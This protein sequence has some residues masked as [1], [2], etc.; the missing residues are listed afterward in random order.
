MREVPC[1]NPGNVT[2]YFDLRLRVELQF[3]STDC[4]NSRFKYV[5]VIFSKPLPSMITFPYHPAL[6]YVKDVIENY[7]MN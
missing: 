4:Q 2:V 6:R 3:L 1:S 7:P 5:K